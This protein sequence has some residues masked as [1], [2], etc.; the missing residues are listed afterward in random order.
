M[1]EETIKELFIK[2]INILTTEKDEIAANIHAIKGQLFDTGKLEAEQSRLQEEL[3]VVAELIQ[4]CVR[5]N[6]RVALDQTEYQKKYDGLAERFNRG[7]RGWMRS[8]MPSRKS[9]RRRSR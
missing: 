1:D 2:A 9:R 4:Q 3:N 7:R 6:A 8:G 5:E